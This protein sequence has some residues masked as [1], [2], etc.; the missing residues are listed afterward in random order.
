MDRIGLN[1]EFGKVTSRKV[2]NSI[3]G[4]CSRDKDYGEVNR[5]LPNN[6][7]KIQK[8]K[9][10]KSTVVKDCRRIVHMKKENEE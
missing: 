7:K 1:M 3:F 5:A 8:N 9:K 10:S 2:Q 4:T 6:T